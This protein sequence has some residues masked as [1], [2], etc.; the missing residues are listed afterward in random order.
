MA[1]FVHVGQCG[2]Q[3]GGAFWSLVDQERRLL[4]ERQGG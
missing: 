4:L 3:L 2:N 1:T